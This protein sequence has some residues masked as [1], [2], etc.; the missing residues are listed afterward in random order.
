MK[1]LPD[2]NGV[3]K[4]HVRRNFRSVSS[5]KRSLATVAKTPKAQP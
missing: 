4:M 3:K 1:A 2:E 5:L